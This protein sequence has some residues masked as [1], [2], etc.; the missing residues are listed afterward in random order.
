MHMLEFMH[1]FEWSK[2]FMQWHTEVIQLA[3]NLPHNFITHM[4]YYTR[5][6][7]CT[8]FSLQERSVQYTAELKSKSPCFHIH[9][10]SGNQPRQTQ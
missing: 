1:Q 5:L 3:T 9:T 10:W 6:Q 4:F 2:S 8:T 7:E